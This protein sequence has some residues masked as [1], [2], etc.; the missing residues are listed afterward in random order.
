MP[1]DQ[2]LS[3]INVLVTR[4]AHQAAFLSD[5]IRA[6]GGNPVLF[7]VLEIT[8]ID[9]QTPLIDLITRLDEFDWAIFVSPNAIN[10]ALKLISEQHSHLPPQLRIAVVGKG[11]ADALKRHG[12]HEVLVPTDQF[13]SEAL[14]KLSELQN[15]KGKRVVIFR[16]NGGRQLLG[17]TLVRRGAI[18]EYAT[19][20]RREKPSV[21]TAPLLTAWSQNQIHAVIVTSSEG[22][23]NLFDIIGS[24]G[25]QLLKSTP[26]FTVHE[27]IALTARDL[28]LKEIVYSPS[29]GDEGLLE[30]LRVYFNSK[31]E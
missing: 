11:S 18:V 10:K 29:H 5:R 14:L 9:D 25:Q 15:M 22:L 8:D 6:M 31:L 23:H 27:R 3:G 28:G 26:I 21:D 4:P 7:P 24:L 16:G 12:I 2:Q 13:D 17:D 19:C 20:Y 30:S 1:L